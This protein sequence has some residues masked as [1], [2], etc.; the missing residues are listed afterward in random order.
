MK[1]GFL[2]Y[3]VKRNKEE[4]LEQIERWIHGSGCDLVVLPELC[5]SGYLYES[6]EA[7]ARAA[8]QVPDGPSVRTMRELSQQENCAIVFGMA[9]MQD[10]LVYNTAVVVDA[11]EYIGHYRKIHLSDYEKRFFQEG[12]PEDQGVFSMRGYTLGVEIC[13]DLWFPE[14]ARVQVRQGANL[15][16][17][18]ANFGGEASCHMARVRAME[19]LTPLV[20]CNRIGREVQP[21]IE[22]DFLGKSALIAPDGERVGE[23]ASDWEGL[24]LTEVTPAGKRSNVICGD[25]LKEMEKH[26]TLLS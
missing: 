26:Y 18:L 17:A 7:L 23:M 24:F 9:E 19:N 8:E 11:G 22:A 6:P 12:D 2:Q 5:L 13:F 16:C 1:A 4:N 3:A 10:G 15:L 21:D 14:V 20:L 25:F